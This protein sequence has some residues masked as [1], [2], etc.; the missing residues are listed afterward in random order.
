[1]QNIPTASLLGWLCTVAASKN[2]AENKPDLNHN[3][4]PTSGRK[5]RHSRRFFDSI[6][7]PECALKLRVTSPAQGPPGKPGLN[8]FFAKKTIG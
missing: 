7:A 4:N 2:T 8:I 6:P 1:M 5:R 3:F